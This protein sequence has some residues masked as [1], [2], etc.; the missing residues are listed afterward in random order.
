MLALYENV[1]ALWK[2]W[3]PIEMLAPYGLRICICWRHWRKMRISLNFTRS[4]FPHYHWSHF[5][6][7]SLRL[8]AYGFHCLDLPL[9]APGRADRY[10]LREWSYEL[11]SLGRPGVGTIIW[12]FLTP[13]S[14]VT[15]VPSVYCSHNA[16]YHFLITR[17]FWRG[18]QQIRKNC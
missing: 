12:R 1:S 16:A 17:G 6:H 11:Y 2:C 10:T 7:F 4:C 3:H 18:S 14:D 8:V 9:G 5:F 13:C 15:S